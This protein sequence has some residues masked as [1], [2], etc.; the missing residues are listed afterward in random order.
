[1]AQRL[2]IS[3]ALATATVFSGLFLTGC[4]DSSS[5]GGNGSAQAADSEGT[6]YPTQPPAAV[7]SAEQ[8]AERQPLAVEPGKIVIGAVSSC[9]PPVKTKATVTN[10]TGEAIEIKR[11]YSNCACTSAK[12]DGSKT[13]GPGESRTVDITIELTGTGQ[14]SQSVYFVGPAGPVGQV[15]VDYEIVPPVRSD[16]DSVVLS[17]ESKNPEFKVVRN[18]GEPVKVKR[19]MTNIGEVRTAADGSQVVVLDLAKA[20]RYAESAAGHSDGSFV[21]DADGE[22]NSMFLLVETDYPGC[23]NAVVFVRR[24]R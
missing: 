11:L 20:D 18:D 21:R 5:G 7:R 3:A 6:P 17:K 15:R 8:R 10:R 1:M 16:V 2:A 12:M 14:K 24:V 4:D 23:P 19:L 13:I 22:W 9:D